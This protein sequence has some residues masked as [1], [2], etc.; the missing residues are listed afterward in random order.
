[1]YVALA[2]ALEAPIVTY[3]APVAMAPGHRARIEVIA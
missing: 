1:V 2:A 3:D